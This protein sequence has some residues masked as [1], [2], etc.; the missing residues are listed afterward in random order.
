M[1]RISFLTEHYLAMI[2]LYLKRFYYRDRFVF[3]IIGGVL[4]MAIVAG[5][6]KVKHELSNPPPP[7]PSPFTIPHS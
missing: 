7:A 6:F 4:I 2:F 5:F 3:L 1:N